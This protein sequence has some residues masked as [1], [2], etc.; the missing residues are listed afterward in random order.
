MGTN[1]FVGDMGEAL[2]R[3]FLKAAG[4]VVLNTN[5]RCRFGE[6]D[7]IARDKEYIVFIEVK[8][9]RSLAFGYPKEAVIKSKQATIRRVAEAYIQ[10][11]NLAGSDFRFDVI[12]ILNDE[13]NHIVNAF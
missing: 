4:Y 13:I 5:F 9:R 12:E 11:H 1:R 10:K 7:I 8:Y 6:I 2:A 3:E